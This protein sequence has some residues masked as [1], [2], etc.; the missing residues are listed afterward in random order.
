MMMRIP[1]SIPSVPV[2]RP[3][4]PHPMRSLRQVSWP[5]E[6]NLFH[7]KEIQIGADGSIVLDK[8]K[9]FVIRPDFFMAPS[10]WG[11]IEYID[12][13]HGT[14]QEQVMGQMMVHERTFCAADVISTSRGPA[15]QAVRRLQRALRRRLYFKWYHAMGGWDGYVK[16][17]VNFVE[18]RGRALRDGTIDPFEPGP[19]WGYVPEPEPAVAELR[20]QDAPWEICVPPVGTLRYSDIQWDRQADAWWAR[21]VAQRAAGESRGNALIVAASPQG[22][23]SQTRG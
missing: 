16:D 7:D 10:L 21:R 23:S 20:D 1:G 11:Q 17:I 8:E 14:R 22:Q 18:C 6:F 13:F 12:Y 3:Q 2:R 5:L 15:F 9:V 4:P 19:A